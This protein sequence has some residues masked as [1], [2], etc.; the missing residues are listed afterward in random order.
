MKHPSPEHPITIEKN[1][2]RVRIVFAGRVAADTNSALILRESTYPPVIYIPRG[3]ADMQWFER[4]ARSTH[5]PYK[6]DASYFT[7]ADG[8]SRFE[9]AV[10]S[11]ESPFSAVAAIKD[12]LA[13]YPQHVQ[14]EEVG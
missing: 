13:F 1:P 7:L 6:G 5:C 2:R 11:Y 3:D 8:E 14:I 9:N 10:W 4:T 12:H